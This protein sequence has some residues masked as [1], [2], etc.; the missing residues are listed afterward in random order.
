MPDNESYRALTDWE[1]QIRSHIYHGAAVNRIQCNSCKDVITSTHR[2]DFVTCKCGA[3]SV[4]GGHDYSSRSY[5][6][7]D[8]GRDAYKEM[9]MPQLIDTKAV[10]MLLDKLNE[11]TTYDNRLTVGEQIALLELAQRLNSVSKL[12]FTSLE[13]VLETC[14]PL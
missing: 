2:H 12:Y 1:A 3:V 5:P 7:G 10:D 9:S 11:K 14:G 6:T 8:E 4:D 13:Y